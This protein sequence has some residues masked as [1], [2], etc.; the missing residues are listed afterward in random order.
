MVKIY[1][2]V[3]MNVLAIPTILG[4]KT[5]KERFAGADFTRTLEGFIA[6][7]G[8]GIQAATSHYLGESIDERHL[9]INLICF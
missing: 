4:T 7:N 1:E 9:S 8:K 5:E 3:Y 2:S 6:T